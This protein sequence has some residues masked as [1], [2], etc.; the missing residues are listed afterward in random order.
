MP[1]SHSEKQSFCLFFCRFLWYFFHISIQV[2]NGLLKMTINIMIKVLLL[3]LLRSERFNGVLVS[4]DG[5]VRDWRCK[6]VAIALL[7]KPID[8]NLFWNKNIQRVPRWR[9]V[10]VRRGF[11]SLAAHQQTTSGRAAAA[12]S[13]AGDAGKSKF[14]AA[15]CGLVHGWAGLVLW[16]AHRANYCTLILLMDWTHLIEVIGSGQG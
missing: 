6:D 5:E 15:W 2:L 16:A 9:V 1:L 4:G 8:T 11:Y 13:S 7:F 14:S 12:Q 3:F 10:T